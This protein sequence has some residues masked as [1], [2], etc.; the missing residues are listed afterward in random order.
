MKG[1]KYFSEVV[2]ISQFDC[3]KL[4]IITAPVGSG[5]SYWALNELAKTA[6]KPCKMIYLIDT[7][8]GKEQLLKNPQTTYYS[9]EWRETVHNGTVYFGE[10]DVSNKVVVMTYAK[11]GALADKYEEFSFDFEIILCDELHSL[12]RFS[13]I[14]RSSNEGKNFHQLAIEEIAGATFNTEGLTIGLTA[15][16]ID[17]EK[18]FGGF[19]GCE[20]A[21]WDYG[22]ELRQYEVKETIPYTNLDTI[23]ATLKPT[24]KGILYVKQIR[25]MIEAEQRAKEAGLAAIPIWSIRNTDHPMTEEQQNARRYLLD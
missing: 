9:D 5:K 12:P 3:S 8:N 23:I 21:Y 7:V 15:T 19:L 25:Q 20:I 16:P 13:N 4:N 22:A 2:D 1:K 10:A 24:E 6:S 11:F 17:F 18:Y 14:S